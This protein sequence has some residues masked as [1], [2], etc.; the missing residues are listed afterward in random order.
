MRP[1][2]LLF[3][4]PGECGGGGEKL[5]VIPSDRLTGYSAKSSFCIHSS[6]AFHFPEKKNS[7]GLFSSE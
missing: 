7:V 1:E 5:K 3:T 2:T 4:N 6:S